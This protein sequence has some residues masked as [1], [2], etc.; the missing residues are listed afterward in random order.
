MLASSA[1]IALENV[2]THERAQDLT[3]VQERQ[4]IVHTLHDTVLQMLFTIGAEA[5]SGV[6]LP[7]LPEDARVKLEL[8]GRLAARSSHELR[9]AMLPLAMSNLALGAG[10]VALL[11]EAARDFQARTGVATT[12]VVSDDFAYPPSPVGEA[13]YRIVREAFSNVRKHARA[14]N[15]V[16]SL[17]S[18]GA[19]ISVTIQDNGVGLARA[20]TAENGETGLHFGVVAMRQLALQAGGQFII[21]NNDDQGVI[22]RATFPVTEGGGA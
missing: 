8:I 14:S 19:S 13:I 6:K 18:T 10:L 17:Q 5:E 22:V 11:E 9:A 21:A 16:V 1:V 12:V 7:D 2:R 20:I 4:Q 3:R 15:V